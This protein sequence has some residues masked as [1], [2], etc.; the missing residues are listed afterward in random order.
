VFLNVGLEILSSQFSASLA[1]K[2]NSIFW[3][4]NSNVCS[5]Y[6]FAAR[7]NFFEGSTIWVIWPAAGDQ[8]VTT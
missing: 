6:S 3:V 2:Q 8:A 1:K 5:T 7:L 4:Q